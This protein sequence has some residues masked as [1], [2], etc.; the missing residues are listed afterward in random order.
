M[1]VQYQQDKGMLV[2]YQQ[3][4]GMLVQ[5]QT[6]IAC[7]SHSENI[8]VREQYMFQYCAVMHVIEILMT[9]CNIQVVGCNRPS[10]RAHFKMFST[11]ELQIAV[12]Q[13][14]FKILCTVE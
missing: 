6:I 4:K 10:I 12:M 1:L 13:T 11:V 2:P 14:N 8:E 7:Q 3:D 5:Y 9:L